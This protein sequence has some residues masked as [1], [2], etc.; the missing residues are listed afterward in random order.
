VFDDDLELELLTGLYILWYGAVLRAV[1]TVAI[2]VMSLQPVPLSD[3]AVRQMVLKAQ[4]SS[5]VVH[6]TTKKMIAQRIADGAARGLTPKQIAYGT[7]DFPGIAGLFDVT[8]KGRPLTVAQTELQRAQLEATVERFQNL[9]R[10]RVTGWL[11]SDGDYDANCAA[12]NGR[13]YPT[14]SP[15]QLLHPNCRL[16]VRPLI[17]L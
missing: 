17:R 15:P 7:P 2:R 10:G 13:T 14:N 9:G 3:V 12:R 5:V 11:A 16:T 8:W 4:A 1:H 6:E